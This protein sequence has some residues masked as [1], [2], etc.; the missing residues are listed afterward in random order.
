MFTCTFGS[1]G[2]QAQLSI[3]HCV[4][5]TL[6]F[7]VENTEPFIVSTVPSTTPSRAL[8]LTSLQYL[9]GASRDPT[10]GGCIGKYKEPQVRWRKTEY[11]QQECGKYRV[12]MSP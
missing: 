9:R 12:R 6:I 11:C 3:W 4:T 5:E 10:V 8:L 1:S 7:A 2:V